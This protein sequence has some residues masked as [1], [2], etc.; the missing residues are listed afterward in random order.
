M[1][2]VQNPAYVAGME[3]R[4][5]AAARH[6]RMVRMLRV[7]VPA[8][9]VVAMAAVVAVSVF[10]PFRMLLPKLLRRL[11][12]GWWPKAMPPR[13]PL[14]LPAW[15]PGWKGCGHLNLSKLPVLYRTW[16]RF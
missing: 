8:A 3:A 2:S 1:N 5:A 11:W 16:T 14:P 15:H 6:S 7:A 12:T 9:V 10:N 13:P 4:F